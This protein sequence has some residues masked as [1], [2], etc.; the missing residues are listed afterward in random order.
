V[1]KPEWLFVGAMLIVGAYFGY[2][3]F[4]KTEA[5]NPLQLV[6]KSSVAVYETNNLPGVYSALKKTKY[7]PDIL[8][9]FS[10]D[11]VS[12]MAIV[13]DSILDKDG[14][15][16]AKLSRNSSIISLHIT[17]NESASLMLYLPTG[18]GSRKFLESTLEKLTSIK[19]VYSTRVYDG[20]TIHELVADDKILTYLNHRDYAIISSVGYL[21][22]DVVR[23]LNEGMVNNFFSIN[24]ELVQ[25]PKFNDDAGNIYLNGQQLSAYSQTLLPA[26]HSEVGILAKSI[27]LDLNLTDQEML[28]SGFLFEDGQD[29][30]TSIFANQEASFPAS[31][32]LVPDNAAMVVSINVSNIDSWYK[33]WISRFPISAEASQ[34]SVGLSQAF[35]KN[36]LGDITLATFS[37]NDKTLNDKLLFINLSDK[38]GVLNLL[39]KQAELI[40]EQEGDSVYFEMYADHRIGLIDINDF[41]ASLLGSPFSGFPSTYYMIYK[42]HII[43]SSSVERLKRWLGDIEDDNVWGRSVVVSSFIAENLGETTFALVLNN[44]W[45]WSWSYDQFNQKHKQWWQK[46]ETTLKQFGLASFQFTNL[47][48]KYYAAVNVLYQPIAI[49][50]GLQALEENSLTQFSHKISKKPKLVKNHV[51]GSWEVLIMDSTNQ[52]SLMSK[53]GEILWSDSLPGP[54]ETEIYQVDYFKNKKLQYLFAIDSVI[55]LIDRNGKS[56]EGFPQ[57]LGN[58]SVD[59]LHL[60]DYDRS[61]NYRFL[62]TDNSGNINM[63]NQQFTALEGWNPLVL[64]SALTNQLFHVRARGKDRIIIAKK[65]GNVEIRNRRGDLQPGFPLDLQFNIDG[66]I[67]F[68]AGSTFKSSMFTTV[69]K[70]GLVVQFDL[71]GSTHLKNQIDMEGSSSEFNL[72]IDGVQNDYIIARQDLNRLTVLSKDGEL[73]FEKDYQVN[74]LKEVQYYSL[75]IDRQL[76][77]IRDTETS[78]VYLYDKDGGLINSTPIYSDHPVSIVYRKSQAKCYIYTAVGQLMEVNNFTF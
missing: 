3:Y 8:E 74:S 41:P 64:N 47:D 12:Q 65:N 46:N 24:S 58:L 33:A 28:L 39:N 61:K 60:I 70:E 57:Q 38:E 31:I 51:D 27:F 2:Q 62:I 42:N 73:I 55:F 26:L 18:V 17:G 40:A 6:P 29:A 4:S 20:L 34:E 69:S 72:I 66:P 53:D 50:T 9:L 25:V 5:F 45:S 54:I 36:I 11:M 56:V 1:K 48:N 75:G 7:W 77:I 15:F 10:R 59:Q 67:H 68:K 49:E 32:K 44:P 13:V 23:N 30:F 76:Y 63:F 16:K 52:F 35:I 71:N 14:R 78:K 37:S 19:P 22:E 21:I 43:L